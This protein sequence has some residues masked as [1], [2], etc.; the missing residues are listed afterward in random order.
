MLVFRSAL[1]PEHAERRWTARRGS[2]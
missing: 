1:G 2:A